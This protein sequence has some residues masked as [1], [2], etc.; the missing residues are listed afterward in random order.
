MRD[1]GLGL[2]R[3]RAQRRNMTVS[4]INNTTETTFATTA[5]AASETMLATTP[6]V[7]PT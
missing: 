1:A 4:M 3:M 2:E 5:P 6:G 7:M